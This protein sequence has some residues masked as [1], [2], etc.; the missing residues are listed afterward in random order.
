MTA[1]RD[2]Q[3]KN[4]NK[5]VDAIKAQLTESAGTI[6]VNYRGLSVSELSELRSVLRESNGTLTVYK[7]NYIK[8]ALDEVGKGM[9]AS[10]S[11]GPTAV[12][13]VA[14]EVPAAAKKILKFAKHHNQL[15]VKGSWVDDKPI[16]NEE[17]KELSQLPSRNELLATFVGTLKGP[18][19]QLVASLS[20]PIRGVVIVL[21]QIKEN[22]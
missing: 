2:L 15:Q 10:V 5:V 20:S 18:I 8:R 21:N 12:I 4:K 1:T 14:E 11:F 17:L 7:N 22:K 13:S 16:S 9:D 3:I 19:N 6:F